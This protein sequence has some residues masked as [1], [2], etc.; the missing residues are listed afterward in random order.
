[1]AR[2][3]LV[4]WMIL[5]WP[6][7]AGAQGGDSARVYTQEAFFSRVLANH[8]VAKQARLLDEQ[9]EAL[10]RQARGGFDP[11]LYAGW[12]QKNF[13]KKEYYALGEGGLKIP[14]WYGV[15]AKA[16]Y[17]LADGVYLNP[18][19]NLPD[20]GQAILG[21][22]VPLGRGLVIDDRRAA[23]RQAALMAQA[24]EAERQSILNSLLLDAAAAYWDWATAYNQLQVQQR[25]LG[26]A[27]GRFDA[28]VENFILGDKPA[29]DTL[30]TL[31]QLQTR[32]AGLLD[33]ALAYRNAG[34]RLSNFL[35]N[36][37]GAPLEITGQLRPPL[38]EALPV[39][40]PPDN[41]WAIQQNAG[42]SHPDIRAYSAKLGQL[43]VSRRLAAE[44][45]KPR[46]D[47]EYNILG[48]GFN[49]VGNTDALLTQ[50]YKWGLNF[51]L[52]LLLRKERG[53]LQL[54]RLKIQETEYGLLQK[55]LEVRNKVESYYNELDNLRQQAALAAENVQ[56][57]QALLQAELQMFDYGES[58]VFLVNSRE[59][60]L[61][62]AELKLAAFRGKFFKALT[63]LEWAAGRLARE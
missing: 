62:E 40:M 21:L 44:Q 33:A 13:D 28:I 43:E 36:E 54:A 19:R 24:N 61:I 34:L 18:E 23:L 10:E 29:V 57:Y 46:L 25:A 32:R 7:W 52:P 5:C 16:A 38:L 51:E 4:L 45:L 56:S 48:D 53:K 2:N 9:S 55:Q 41:V 59:Q 47:V 35:W 1:M 14:T 3:K 26:Q 11:K 17:A 37:D 12:S 8:P 49:L 20:A 31:I 60:K 15:E 39:Q 6:L 30:E 22:T 58:S 50:N 27:Q 42:Q 63:G